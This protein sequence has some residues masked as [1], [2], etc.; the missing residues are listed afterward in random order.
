M[1]VFLI[2]ST[3]DFIAFP[4]VSTDNYITIVRANNAFSLVFH[5]SCWSIL[6]GLRYLL[7]IHESWIRSKFPNLSTLG[8]IAI[9]ALF[10][11]FFSN[12]GLILSVSIASGWPK[13]KLPEMPMWKQFI[14]GGTLFG[15]YFLLIFSSFIIYAL[16]LH[17]RT[18]M[19][20][21]IVPELIKEDSNEVKPD[22]SEDNV[23]PTMEAQEFDISRVSNQYLYRAHCKCC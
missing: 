21:E 19:S 16:I 17:A 10:L 4:F 11:L 3:I 14:T 20:N 7:I 23:S 8:Q 5:C 6:S 9:L 15:I 2:S 13:T 1:L 22:S 12:L 18:K